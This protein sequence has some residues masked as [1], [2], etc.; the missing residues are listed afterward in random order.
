MPLFHSLLWLSNIPFCIYTTSSWSTPLSMD[1]YIVSMSW[2]LYIVLLWTLEYMYLFESWFS[3]DICQGVGLLD[4]M[5]NLFLVFWGNSIMFSTVVA[6]IY[7]P[8]KV[9]GSLFTTPSPAFIVCRLFDEGHSGLYKVAPHSGFE[10]YFSNNEW[11]WTS[12]H[13][14][15]GHLSVFLGDLSAYVFC[16]FFDFFFMLNCRRYLYILEINPLSVT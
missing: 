8:S 5:V 1:I 3:L 7:I 12:F 6:P 11:C 4:Q 15:F 16:P 2:L 9:Y 13:V 14:F 10:M